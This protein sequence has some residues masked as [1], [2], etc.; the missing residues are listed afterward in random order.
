MWGRTQ[1]ESTWIQLYLKG[2]I[3]LGLPN[4]MDQ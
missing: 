4:Y 2:R 1:R 3:T